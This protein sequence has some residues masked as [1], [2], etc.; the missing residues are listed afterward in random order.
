MDIAQIKNIEII[1]A[2][3]KDMLDYFNKKFLDDLEEIQLLKTKIFEIDIKIEELMKRKDI[4]SF[5]H[6]S[7]KNVF[8][9]IASDNMQEEHSKQIDIQIAD[10]QEVKQTLI[11]KMRGLEHSLSYLKNRLTTLNEAASAIDSV[12]A[13]YSDEAKQEAKAMDEFEFVEEAADEGALSHGYNILMQNAFDDAYLSTLIDK[14]IK[15]NISGIKHKLDMLSYLITTDASRAKLTLGEIKQASDTTLRHV[16][17]IYQMLA[18]GVDT[19]KP[20]WSLI[21]DFIMNM[22]EAHPE[23]IIT[24]NVEC[25]DYDTNL[26][27]VFTINLFKLLN[28]FFDN[29]F[30]HSNAN[31]L[32]FSI[33]LSQNVV[34]VVLVD[35][36]VGIDVN[37]LT[38]SPW[39]S[40]LHKAHEIIYLLGGNLNISGNLLSGTMV[41][42]Q[43]PVQK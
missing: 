12:M 21:D 31:N 37:Y 9:P 15:E 6:T 20:I 40:S 28:I 29:V 39:Y 18:E 5:K 38:K 8:S 33:S 1:Q 32:D 2:A 14:N 34:D 4:Y 10:H 25:S 22:R 24:A 11:T 30:K 42:F 7:R 41:R 16:N 27:P 13:D 36:G 23:C 43:F 19:A 35:N 26:H 3:N 17:D